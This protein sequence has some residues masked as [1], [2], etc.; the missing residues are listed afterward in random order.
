MTLHARGWL[1]RYAAALGTAP[2]SD[3]DL[4]ALLTLSGVAAHA[5]ERKAAPVS[6]YLVARSGLPIAD[7]LAAARALADE[8][9]ELEDGDDTG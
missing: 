9:A 5:S 6:C 3:K 4:E 2:V 8:V 7:A 1:D